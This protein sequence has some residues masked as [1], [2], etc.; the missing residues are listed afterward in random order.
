LTADGGIANM[1]DRGES[2][3]PR[4]AAAMTALF[5]S[6]IEDEMVLKQGVDYVTSQLPSAQNEERRESCFFYS[7]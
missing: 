5:M 2:G 4:S 6:G 3:L 1:A 7:R